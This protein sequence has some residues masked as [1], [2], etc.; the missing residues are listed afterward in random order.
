MY[1]SLI[2]NTSRKVAV[3]KVSKSLLL[4]YT[5]PKFQTL[6]KMITLII[7]SFYSMLYRG[8]LQTPT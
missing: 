2:S 7:N 8:V 3:Q 4:R 6:A 5:L 1:F